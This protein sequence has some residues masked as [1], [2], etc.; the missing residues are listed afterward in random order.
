S[1]V[2]DDCSLYE[3]QKVLRGSECIFE[4]AMCQGCGED[5]TQE[6]SEESL[7]TMK[8]FLLCNFRP[9]LADDQCHFCSAPKTAFKNYTLLGVCQGLENLGSSLV[10]PRI[11]MCEDCSEG[12]QQ[13]LSKKT[14]DIQ[15]DFVRDFFPGIPADMD[16]SPIGTCF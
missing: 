10:F 3:V 7:K 2:L 13:K 9:S 14:R 11:V 5:L 8:G 16:F 15:G 4:M 12:L 1:Q 6:F